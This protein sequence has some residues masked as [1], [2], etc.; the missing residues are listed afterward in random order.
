VNAAVAE[1]VDGATIAIDNGE[2][3]EPHME[4]PALT[5]DMAEN[6]ARLQAE[7]YGVDDDN[8]PAPEN[9]PLPNDQQ[10][11]D[12]IYSQWGS[13]NVCNRRSNGHHEENARVH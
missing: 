1:E 10:Q 8:E 2:D 6:V 12:N 7:G 13:K 3:L 11:E 5:N 4:V 9:I